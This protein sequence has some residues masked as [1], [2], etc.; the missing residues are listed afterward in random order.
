MTSADVRPKVT[1]E[2]GKREKVRRRRMK[3]EGRREKEEGRRKKKKKYIES[4]SLGA[5]A[6][7]TH[8]DRLVSQ[9]M[10]S[11][12]PR[13]GLSLDR[14]ISI[15]LLC[16][17]PPPTRARARAHLLLPLLRARIPTPLPALI[18]IQIRIS[19][20]RSSFTL[21]Q[22]DRAPAGISLVMPVERVQARECLAAPVAFVW[23]HVEVEGLVAF[24]LRCGR[25]KGGDERGRAKDGDKIRSVRP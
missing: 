18:Q 10:S 15:L 20:T 24:A 5:T 16:R 2:N 4:H 9:H 22:L 11:K 7:C 21:S 14:S 12:P 17:P 13:T 1:E 6:Q 3:E 23:F 19:Q 8:R 25:A